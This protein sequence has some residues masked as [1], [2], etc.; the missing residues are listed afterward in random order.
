M[1]LSAFKTKATNIYN[2]IKQMVIDGTIDEQ[3]A[4]ELFVVVIGKVVEKE[5]LDNG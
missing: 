1:K 3:T 2:T 4:R 5:Y